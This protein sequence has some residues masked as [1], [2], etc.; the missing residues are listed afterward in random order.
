MIGISG[1]ASV[2]NVSPW[3]DLRNEKSKNLPKNVEPTLTKDNVIFINDL[4]GKKPEERIDEIYKKYIDE[5]NEKTKRNS[6]RIHITGDAKW[7]SPK[8][9]I[10]DKKTGKTIEKPR[11]EEFT[12][13]CDYHKKKLASGNK[14]N[15]KLV[16]EEVWQFGEGATLGGKYFNATGKEREKIHDFYE[17]A[18]KEMLEKWQKK[19]PRIHVLYAVVHF[20][21]P[22]GAPQMHVCYFGEGEG[23]SQGLKNRVSLANALT[24]CG[25]ERL[26]KRSDAKEVG[27]QRSRFVGDTRDNIVKGFIREHQKEISDILGDEIYIKPEKHGREHTDSAEMNKENQKAVAE[28]TRAEVKQEAAPIIAELKGMQRDAKT[29]DKPFLEKMDEAL[30]FMNDDDYREAKT[31]LKN[32]A[33]RKL[34][35]KVDG[36]TLEREERLQEIPQRTEQLEAD[37]DGIDFSDELEDQYLPEE[38]EEPEA[39][40]YA[41]Q[42]APEAPQ[43]PSEPIYEESPYESSYEPQEAPREP[44]KPF[45]F[46]GAFAERVANLNRG[47]AERNA[48]KAKYQQE[49]EAMRRHAGYEPWEDSESDS[50]DYQPGS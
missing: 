1:S 17:S 29:A 48:G 47:K 18:Y 28:M 19:N 22:D 50:D 5:F 20:D 21:E 38:E 23:Y 37:L 12:G 45:E 27:Y 4:N 25:Y 2:G 40:L 36:Q 16:W 24:A 35:D 43:K 3:H 33:L 11:Y 6:S 42:K 32:P 14:K 7:A 10:I 44:K 13:Y 8:K 9:K 15:N 30:P 26:D 46:K 41:P 34:V 31:A 39:P 49:G